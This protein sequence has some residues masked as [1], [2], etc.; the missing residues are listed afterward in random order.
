MLSVSCAQTCHWRGNQQFFLDPLGR[1]RPY[2]NINR[3]VDVRGANP[4][5]RTPI[6][7]WDCLDVPQQKWY[8][9]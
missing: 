8:I 7:L 3:C 5:E 6:Q 9:A 4:A 1:L 2:S